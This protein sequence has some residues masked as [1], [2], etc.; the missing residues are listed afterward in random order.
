MPV[1]DKKF[2][3]GSSDIAVEECVKLEV[4]NFTSDLEACLKEFSWKG[5]T[6]A[7]VG[8]MLSAD[9]KKVDSGNFILVG[10][11]QD[12]KE[13]AVKI[14]PGCKEGVILRIKCKSATAFPFS[15]GGLS[16]DLV[17]QDRLEHAFFAQNNDGP[18]TV[19]LEA[20][21]EEYGI[22]EFCTRVIYGVSK[23]SSAKEG[24]VI[25]YSM[26][27]F[28][29]GKEELAKFE[30]A[31]EAAWPGLLATEGECPLMVRA[32]ELW[33]CPIWPLLL[34]GEDLE[35]QPHLPGGEEL[36]VA[37]AGVMANAVTPETSKSAK[38][39][40]SRWKKLAANHEEMTAK[41]SQPE[42]PRPQ[43]RPNETGEYQFSLIYLL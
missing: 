23:N 6:A 33:G 36:R 32:T 27:L 7:C 42:W 16:S 29:L 28:P 5:D 30:G 39:L 31:K 40:H 3:A 37:I 38:S 14:W 9:K 8:L 34:T 41:R 25:K 15:R 19:I 26:L 11:L 4:R 22:G 20:E 12:V 18:P 13:E 21:Y 17:S 10:P 2:F 1:L 24:I 43:Q 35:M